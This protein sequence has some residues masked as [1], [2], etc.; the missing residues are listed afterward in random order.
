MKKLES[1]I[2]VPLGQYDEAQLYA[3]SY[4]A[5]I[6]GKK[7]KYLPSPVAGAVSLAITPRQVRCIVR[8]W[9]KKREIVHIPSFTIDPS[10]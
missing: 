5:G 2:S 9:L 3:V 7:A 8:G 4:L 1:R 6:F 10:L